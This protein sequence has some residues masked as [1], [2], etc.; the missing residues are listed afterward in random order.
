VGVSQSKSTKSGYSVRLNF[1]MGQHKRDSL[2]MKN[3][4]KYLSCGEFYPKPERS[5]GEFIVSKFPEIESKI[6]PFFNKYPLHGDKSKDFDS[7][8]RAAVIIQNKGHLTTEGLEEI[9][10]KRLRLKGVLNSSRY[11][12]LKEE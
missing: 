10:I 12:S 11:A 7:F 3:I 5:I 1:S 4:S 9:R 2:L 6:I 8:K